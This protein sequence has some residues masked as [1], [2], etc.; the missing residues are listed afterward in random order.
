M[1]RHPKHKIKVFKQGTPG[2]LDNKGVIPEPDIV[3]TTDGTPVRVGKE[4]TNYKKSTKVYEK[5]PETN[6]VIES[7]MVVPYVSN[8]TFPDYI[9]MMIEGYDW[10][11]QMVQYVQN[12]VR[13]PLYQQKFDW[14]VTE[15]F[16]RVKP[17]KYLIM[18]ASDNYMNPQDLGR[19]R[20]LLDNDPK[21]FAVGIYPIGQ[22][23]A[24]TK[25]FKDFV[26]PTR[27]AFW[28]AAIFGKFKKAGMDRSKQVFKGIPLD[29]VYFIAQE[30]IKAGYHSMVD[31]KSRPYRI[32][33]AEFKTF[34]INPTA[35]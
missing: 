33:E 15:T 22:H 17:T 7:M 11:P 30:A 1:G 13:L 31:P 20:T 21:C 19:M 27:I 29:S 24:H 9:R 14:K 8:K 26:M 35:A 16:D 2:A 23:M 25:L 4:G 6:E 28:N 5:A 10:M 18:H 34:W 32:D 3:T 12:D